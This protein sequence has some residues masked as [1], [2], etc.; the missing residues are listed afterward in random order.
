MGRNGL[1]GIVFAAGRKRS[2]RSAPPISIKSRLLHR[3][4]CFFKA[5]DLADMLGGVGELEAEADTLAV[6]A[7]RKAPAPNHGYVVGMWACVGLRHDFARPEAL[8]QDEPR[9][10]S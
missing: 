8:R 1:A 5:L 3:P 6:S 10:R 2:W 9:K 7:C 4:T